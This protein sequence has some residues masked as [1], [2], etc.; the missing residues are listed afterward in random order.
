MSQEP[1]D[2]PDSDEATLS[3]D[4]LRL[5]YETAQTTRHLD[6]QMDRAFDEI[7]QN[8]QEV[9]EAKRTAQRNKTI[10]GGISVGLTS[11]SLWFADKVSRVL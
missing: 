4:E 11:L 7:D 1:V 3:D 2:Y 10:L 9:A 8:A 6:D 5:L